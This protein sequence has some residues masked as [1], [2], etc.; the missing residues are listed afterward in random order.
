MSMCKDSGQR[1]KLSRLCADCWLIRRTACC[2]AQQA[3]TPLVEK[4]SRSP[5]LA[6]WKSVE[7]AAEAQSLRLFPLLASCVLRQIPEGLIPDHYSFLFGGQNLG[8][9]RPLL[10]VVRSCTDI[11]ILPCKQA[12]MEYSS[13]PR[14]DLPPCSMRWWTV[15]KGIYACICV[16]TIRQTTTQRALP[17]QLS[18]P[19]FWSG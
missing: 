7:E 16:V 3:L 17:G 4:L 5:R 6:I 2:C 8:N 13:K 11:D 1:G 9:G 12:D 18:Q 15:H 10:L 19:L 14:R